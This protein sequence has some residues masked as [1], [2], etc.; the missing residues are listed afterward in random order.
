MTVHRCRL[1]LRTRN[2]KEF[3]NEI[4]DC[5]DSGLELEEPP[6]SE[7]LMLVVEDNDKESIKRLVDAYIKKYPEL[8]KNKANRAN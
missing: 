8:A 4:W 3:F 2:G 7:K 5:P 1:F 6:Q